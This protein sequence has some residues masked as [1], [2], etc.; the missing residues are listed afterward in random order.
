VNTQKQIMIIVGL[1]FL[2]IIATGAYWMWDPTRAEN[3][4]EHQLETTVWRGAFLFSQNCRTCHGDAGEGGVAS[5]RLREAPALNRPDLQGID[6]DTGEVDEQAKDRQFDLIFNTINCGRVGKA[7]PTWG[8]AQGGVLN[9]EQIRQ[10]TTMITEGTGWEDAV[11]FA[12]EGFPQGEVHGDAEVPFELEE[13]V[14]VDADT[15][16][17]SGD[18]SG[19]VVNDRIQI[20]DELTVITAIEAESGE[21]T[22]ERGFGNTSPADHEAGAELLK[23]PVPPDPAPITEA[24]CG[25]T[26]GAAEPT[27]TPA[28][29]SATLAITSQANLFSLAQMNALPGVPLTLTHD[30]QDDGV[31]H[32][33]ELFANE[34][35]VAAGEDA[36]AATEIESGPV[37]QTLNFGPLDEG[38]YYYQ[39]AI[40]PGTMFG[41]L[42]AAAA[43]AAPPAEDAAAPTTD[44]AAT[45]EAT[46][47]P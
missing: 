29:P 14:A 18:L 38:E 19:L 33:W 25:Q 42:I 1:V 26:A 35:A 23:P 12:I 10:L 21:I 27:A 44:G 43:D 4:T 41:T 20:E 32:N 16:V 22:V 3:A 30:N 6:P 13:A 46:P 24:A 2:S 31:Q 7:M 9:D 8:Q 11:E 45:P 40:H 47:V 36:I 28:P 15:I 34:E 17:L 39:C 5:N 37:V